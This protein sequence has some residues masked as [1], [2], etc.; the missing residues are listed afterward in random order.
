MF[1]K[2]TL[3][4]ILKDADM[5]IEELCLVGIDFSPIYT[6]SAIDCFLSIKDFIAT[7]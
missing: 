7:G 2:G 1:R 4:A 3:H 5:S 6:L